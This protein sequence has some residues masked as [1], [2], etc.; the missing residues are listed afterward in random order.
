MSYE[1]PDA[2]DVIVVGAGHAGCEAALA[3]AR[4]G[5]RVLVLTGSLEMVAQMS[6]N[7]AIGGVAKGHIVKEI[8]ALGGEMAS[9]IDQT[10]IQ[11]R[12]LNASK[13]P[14]VRSTRA[15]ADKRRYRD[16][17]RMRLERCERLALRQGEVAE[18]HVDR[19]ARGVRPRVVGVTTTIGVRYRASA[20]ILTTGTFLR[21]A[22]FVGESRGAGGRAGEAPAVSLSHSLD[23][24]G[25]PLARLKTGTPCRLDR[26]TIDLASLEVQPGDE[27]APMFRWAGR[28]QPALPQVPCWITYTNERT[29]AIIRDGLPRSPLYRKEIQGTGPRYCP[30]IED[31]IV[32]F[33]DKERHQIFL[34]PEGV[35][36]GLGGAGEVY[37]NGIST[38]LPFDLQLAF[39]RT[40]PGLERAEM[41]RP[42]YAV[43]YDFIDPREVLPTLEA[44][45]VRGLYHAGQINGTS[46]YEEAAVQ[47]LLAGINAA[48]ALG[49]GPGDREPLILRRD[50]A[51]AGVLVDDL[52][53]RGTTEPYRM[54]TS[55]AE[56]RL[57]LRE[58]NTVDRLMP[59]GRRLGL[60]DDARW[61]AYEAWCAELAAARERA[62][63]A[64][65]MGSD[66]VNAQLARFGSAPVVG[67]RATLAEL[68]RRPELD[69]RAVEQIADAG[70]VAR[71]DASPAALERLEIE[72]VY[73]GYLRRQEVD[74]AKLQRA[75]G[76]LVPDALEFREIPGLSNEAVEKLEAIRPRSVGQASRISGVTPAAVAILL[77]HIG[78]V[79]RRKAEVA[80]RS[81]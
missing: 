70:G 13:G 12:R 63:R 27:P 44:R 72:L 23:A 53:T 52:T 22:I 61:R 76:V 51:Y 66:A 60:V 10:G 47:G 7:P 59:I 14:A 46:G 77:T 45:R 24:L 37:P 57:L 33:A 41:T 31:K 74:A 56:F 39:L 55:R 16:E 62:A 69:W 81:P 3:A 11:F 49:F 18:L 54:M 29:H 2:Y 58:D 40:I 32:R 38:S 20:V 8:D 43:E 17:M 71:S 68:L 26:R 4:I 5:A 21:G 35:E 34:E 79:E 48:L 65:V 19:D 25:F 80:S 64:Q 1:Y 78:L 67:R 42:G 6:C 9:V 28:T 36:V 50:Q 73:E 30:S 75:D 15:Q